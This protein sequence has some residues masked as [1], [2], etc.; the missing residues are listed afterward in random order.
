MAGGA[1]ARGA[2]A[3]PV[4][5]FI[6]AGAREQA[7]ARLAALAAEIDVAQ[8]ALAVAEEAVAQVAAR[9]AVL[10]GEVGAAPGDQELRDAHGKAAAAR[11]TLRLTTGKVEQQQ[12]VVT[13]VDRADR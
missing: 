4:A 12:A 3:K 7:R 8:Q 9:L 2:W 1:A 13:G 11:E 10:A 6:G 5:E